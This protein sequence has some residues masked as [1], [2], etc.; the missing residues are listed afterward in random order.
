MIKQIK[1]LIKGRRGFTLIELVVVIAIMGVLAAVAVPLVNS[2]LARSKE[3]A[4]N[5]DVALIQSAIDAFFTSPTNVR[6]HGLRQYPLIGFSSTGTLD[7]WKDTPVDLTSDS[8]D[9]AKPLNPFR[10]SKGGDPKWRDTSPSD[11]LRSA[12]EENLN[13]EDNTIAGSGSGWYVVKKDL[14]GVDYAV[15]SRDYFIDFTQ[16]IAAGL[17]K[18]VPASVS[19]DNPGGSADGSYSWYVDPDGVV[20]A[21]QV[22]FP[23]N[24]VAFNGTTGATADGPDNRGF[25]EG[26]FP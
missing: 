2:N 9:L 6:H 11:G 21:L 19:T 14:E 22:H 1:N 15:D 20:T 18:K 16:L 26:V 17:L 8:A 24:G 5:T 13:A 25:Q 4:F 7:R 3:R 10:G 23:T 12:D